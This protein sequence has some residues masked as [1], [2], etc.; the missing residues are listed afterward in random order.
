M[1]KRP[2]LPLVLFVLFICFAAG[3]V[4]VFLKQGS[5]SDPLASPEPPSNLETTLPIGDATTSPQTTILVIGVDQL[6]TETPKLEAIWFVT[7]R[8]PGRDLFLL[9]IP[10]NAR[11][12]VQP[13]LRLK[14]LFRWSVDQGPDAIFMQAL[15]DEVPLSIDV[16][17]VVDEIAFAALIDYMGGV[18]LES[19]TL[20]GNQ[21]IGVLD[22]VKDQPT[23]ALEVQE[24]VVQALSEKAPNLGS[25]PDLTPLIALIPI[26]AYSSIPP[27]NL[28]AL[29]NPLLP[30]QPNTVHIELMPLDG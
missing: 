18:T 29:I 27:L 9:G 6:Q 22:L 16:I 12:R 23:A 3:L 30:I 20:D 7:F 28:V 19:G 1:I 24:R 25:T 10:I 15:Y 13:E 17:L 26:N 5:E 8:L 4:S 21:V 14:D 11:V 2:S